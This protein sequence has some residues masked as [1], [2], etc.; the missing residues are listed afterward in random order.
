MADSATQ[1]K[2]LRKQSL[3]SNV[4]TWGDTKLNEVLDVIDQIV[5]GVETINL[6]GDI[7][8]TTTNYTT[9][10]QAKYRIIR[11]TGTVAANVTFPSVQGWYGLIN[12]NSAAVTAKT[13]GGTGIAIPSSRTV[14]VYCDATDFFSLVPNFLPT[15][16]TLTNDQDLVSRLQMSTAIATAALPATSGTLLNSV[17]DTTAGYG[18][19]KNTALSLGGLVRSTLNGGANEQNQFALDFTNLT[20][21]ANVAG[22]DRFAV[23]D[24]TAGVMRYQTRALAVG[25]FGLANQASSATVNP[26]VAGNLYPLDCT[27]GA[28]AVTFPAS[29]AAGDVFGLIIYGT[30]GWAV[31]TNSLNYYGAAYAALAG[32][33]EGISLFYYT[34]A[35]RGW[36]DA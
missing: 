10:D 22:T 27:A 11:F 8:L 1:R 5:D 19:A 13:S 23:Y 28:G 32:S 21:T 16:T 4:N 25:K 7:T 24:A 35:S 2:R 15:A 14:I 6:T 18:S 31:N 12:A 29:A 17:T 9:A 26:V 20:V 33:D 34:G 3:G 30:N 36:I